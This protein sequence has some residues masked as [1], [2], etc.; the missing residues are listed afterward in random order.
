M[1]FT[2]LGSSTLTSSFKQ[3]GVG[4]QLTGADAQ[5]WEIPGTHTTTTPTP[6]KAA[7]ESG[8]RQG[9]VGQGPPP[10]HK[11]RSQNNTGVSA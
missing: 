10:N 1:D 4:V 2:Q 8:M 5:L 7:L 9:R 6:G 11:G 3:L